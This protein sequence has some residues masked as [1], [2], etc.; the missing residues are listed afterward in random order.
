MS[1]LSIFWSLTLFCFAKLEDRLVRREANPSNGWTEQAKET[2]GR[3]WYHPVQGK[4]KVLD[5]M[6]E[7]ENSFLQKGRELSIALMISMSYFLS[8]QLTEQHMRSLKGYELKA[9]T[10][11]I[12]I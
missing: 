2:D 10:T 3:K 5:K 1:L 7:W 12:N 6:K 11:C 9:K 8:T 4:F